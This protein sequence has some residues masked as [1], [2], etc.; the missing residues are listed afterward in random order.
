LKGLARW[1]GLTLAS[2]DWDAMRAALRAAA[3]TWSDIEMT[4][5][6]RGSRRQNRWIGMSG[7]RG[8]LHLVA[9]G[10]TMARIDPLLRR[11]MVADHQRVRDQ[12]PVKTAD[13]VNGSYS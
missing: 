7:V 8:L 13:S 3:W 2:V 1:H 12:G 5:W 10:N 4:D 6:H 9:A 11:E